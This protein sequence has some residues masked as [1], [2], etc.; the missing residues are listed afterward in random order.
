MTF[1]GFHAPYEPCPCESNDVTL[2]ETSSLRIVSFNIKVFNSNKNYFNELLHKHDIILLQEHWLFNYEKEQLKQ[3]YS[4]FLTFSRHIDDDEP[5]SPIGRPRGHGGIAILYRKSMSS[6][7]SQLPDG[8]NRVQAI[9]ISTTGNP[10]C[11][12]N[13][14]LPSRG[15]DSGH[16]AYR[17]A[18]DTLKEIILKY[19]ETHSIITAG[20]FN[21]SFIKHYKDSQDELFKQFVK[22]MEWNFQL[23]SKRI[24]RSIQRQQSADKRNQLHEEIMKASDRDNELFFRL[25]KTQRSSSSQFTHTLQT[26]DKEASKPDDINEL[27]KEHF[28]NL[29]K[30]NENPFFDKEHDNL[31][32]LN[33]ETI[34]KLCENEDITVQPVTS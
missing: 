25:I 4:D 34:V 10:T 33:A 29:A 15:T 2:E 27:F 23:D 31:V 20:D 30:T 6:M 1:P 5:M 19:Q 11:L 32:K 9:E 7:F 26:P 18:L 14:Y 16:D 12:I 3:H 13:V 24:V 8:N 22:R 21:A 28:V 17:A